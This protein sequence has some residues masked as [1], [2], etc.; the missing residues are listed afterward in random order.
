MSKL[1][2]CLTLTTAASLN[3][4]NMIGTGVFLKARVM[5]CNVDSPLTV[6]AVWCA[7]GVL[8]LAGALCYAEL[9]AMLPEAGGEYVYMSRA[10][11]PRAGFL[12]CWGYTMITRPASIAAQSVSTA[13]F[14]NIVLGGALADHLALVSVSGINVE[15]PLAGTLLIICNDDQPGVI[16]EVGTIAGCMVSQGRVA[17]AGD[18]QAGLDTGFPT[19]TCAGA[20]SERGRSRWGDAECPRG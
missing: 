17:R 15:A 18:A 6:L 9:A 3:I 4:A 20:K 10:Y 13:I 16:G 5:T 12:W 7:A 11:G 19:R 14:L 2:R 1:V 8:V